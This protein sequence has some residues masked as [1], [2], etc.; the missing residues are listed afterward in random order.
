MPRRAPQLPKG[1]GIA[2]QLRELKA[3]TGMTGAVHDAQV[4]QLKA[5]GW[6]C[7]LQVHHR[8]LE[9]EVD[10]DDFRITYRWA[11][12]G[13]PPKDFGKRLA[14]LVLGIRQL[15][16]VEWSASVVGEGKL[17]YEGQPL[18]SPEKAKNERSKG[19]KR[20]IER[21]GRRAAKRRAGA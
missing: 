4:L 16:G 14:C 12:A 15:L 10:T 8:E 21:I 1:S 19:L 20:E 11:K 17:L 18:V 2:A 13:K 9:I 6:G 3:V 7:F 5:L